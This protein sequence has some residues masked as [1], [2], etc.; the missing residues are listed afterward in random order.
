[1]MPLDYGRF[2]HIYNRGINEENLFIT[3]DH[4]MQFLSYYEKYINP[5]ADTYSWVLMRNH[6]HMLIRIKEIDEIGK[7]YIHIVKGQNKSKF[8][9]SG[10]SNLA[11]FEDPVRVIHEKVPNPTKHFSHL[12]NSYAKYF[13]IQSDR[14][15]SLFQRP[16]KRIQ[17][18]SLEYLRT[19]V[20]YIHN[21][22]VHHGFVDHCFEYLWSSYH[23]MVANN[24]THLKRK[25]VLDWFDDR[26][27]FIVVHARKFQC[28]D[29]EDLLLE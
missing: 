1:M 18:N 24:S 4:F 21:N 7:Y 12:F 28:N 5:I 26:E 22:P 13:N 2:Y 11:E 14:T 23:T 29:I 8:Q 27:N 17:I 6:F 19:L 10:T 15:G 25:E 9:T 16:F 20:V 3:N